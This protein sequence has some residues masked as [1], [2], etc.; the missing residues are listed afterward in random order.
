MF[1]GELRAVDDRRCRGRVVVFA[2]VHGIRRADRGPP[3]H[4]SAPAS[5]RPLRRDL[6][7]AVLSATGEP[8]LGGAA[9]ASS[10][11]GAAVRAGFADA[12]RAVL[13][14]DQAAMLPALVLGDTSTLHRRR[15]STSS[16]PRG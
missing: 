9:S 11:R 10:G 5:A 13:P 3:G 4:A 7:V 12:A 14:A 8:T 2:P 15:R 1:R 16:G 6:T